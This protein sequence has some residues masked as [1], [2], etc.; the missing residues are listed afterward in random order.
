MSWFKT[1][2]HLPG[3]TE[4]KQ[5]NTVR[6]TCVWARI[7]TRDLL[8]KKFVHWMKHSLQKL[9]C[10]RNCYW[11]SNFWRRVGVQHTHSHNMWTRR[12][13]VTFDTTAVGLSVLSN[14]KSSSKEEL[15][16]HQTNNKLD[17]GDI[18]TGLPRSQIMIYA[19]HIQCLLFLLYWLIIP[20]IFR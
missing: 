12:Q 7:W 13:H 17:L 4:K 3:G 9:H 1:S 15:R 2:Q 18:V 19:L 10:K 5:K 16:L 11:H 14:T 6:I 20:L 8:K